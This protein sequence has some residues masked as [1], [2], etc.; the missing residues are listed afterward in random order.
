MSRSKPFVWAFAL[1]FSG[2]GFLVVMWTLV[3]PVLIAGFN[4]RISGELA[5]Q[6]LNGIISVDLALIG[7]GLYVG[8]R[9][10]S[11]ALVRS[12]SATLLL[13]VA[14][15]LSV[16]FSM[17]YLDQYV[18]PVIFAWPLFFMVCGVL[19]VLYLLSLRKQSSAQVARRKEEHDSKD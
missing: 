17:S 4:P 2:Y 6:I 11:R 1:I 15:I 12:T 8:L 9:S 3:L 18:T 10:T 14:S 16:L 5:S 7:Y 13:L 19:A